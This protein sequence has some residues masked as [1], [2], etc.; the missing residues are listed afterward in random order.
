MMIFIREVLYAIQLIMLLLHLLI[1]MLFVVVVDH[2]LY[3]YGI[4]VML[5]TVG[6]DVMYVILV[7]LI[8]YLKKRYC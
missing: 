1:A 3:Y 4:I 8:C 2:S 6:I 5:L 7:L